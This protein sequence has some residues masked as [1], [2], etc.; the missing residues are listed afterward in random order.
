MTKKNT[1]R[2]KTQ[3]IQVGRK[4][5]SSSPLV[6]EVARRADGGLSNRET[7]FNTLLPR[8]TAVLP[9]QGREMSR[10]FTLIELLVVV[11]IIGILAAVAV[12][13]Y[14]IAVTKSR[15][16]TMLG[17][18]ASIADAQEVYYLA[19][20]SY[21][22]QTDLLDVGV[23]GECVH[24][25]NDGYNTPDDGEM[26]TCGKYFLLDNAAAFGTVNIS[27]C[28]DYNTT[29]QDCSDNRDFRVAFQLLHAEDREGQKVCFVYQN[30]K[31]GKTI[32]SN[33]GGFSCANC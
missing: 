31:L 2:G 6:G 17:L 26:F 28:P 25:E 32:C 22:G 18:A 3:Q 4:L 30:S 21:A 13:Q 24:I 33:L 15:V 23:P 12:P 14:K 1:R 20:G 29:W 9:P 16:S 27:Y 10:G 8:L 19:N 11:L 7:F 5:F